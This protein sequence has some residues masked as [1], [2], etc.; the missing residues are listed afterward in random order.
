MYSIVMRVGVFVIVGI[1]V[2]IR[3]C[4]AGLAQDP[5]MR[6]RPDPGTAAAGLFFLW[7]L[8]GIV[9]GI[10]VVAASLA[11][12]PSQEVNGDP[13]PR[14]LA[15]SLELLLVGAVVFIVVTLVGPYATL[16]VLRRWRRFSSPDNTAQTRAFLGLEDPT[17]GPVVHGGR[18][19]V[20]I[21][22]LSIEL[23][24]EWYA[25]NLTHRGLLASAGE[26]GANVRQAAEAALASP[27]RD[28]THLM[29]AYVGS[30]IARSICDIVTAQDLPEGRSELYSL[31]V[32]AAREMVL[33][34]SEWREPESKP[35]VWRAR[36]TAG[37][38]TKV[39][40]QCDIGS[41]YRRW[42]AVGYLLL[43]S[44][45]PIYVEFREHHVGGSAISG[46]R[47]QVLGDTLT[48]G[49]PTH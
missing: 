2:A 9:A 8:M 41:R 37:R 14:D 10:A 31:P 20:P 42:D 47:W 5:V 34:L 27:P 39:R 38:A 22:R 45:P 30:P 49:R 33:R 7:L 17:R 28:A 43:E 13:L 23:P 6:R 32:E 36:L 48:V 12:R 46:E 24:M 19:D 16:P 26:F 3:G 40:F 21:A 11:L 44:D 25:F 35:S 15:P 29:H 18:I 4:V 1:I